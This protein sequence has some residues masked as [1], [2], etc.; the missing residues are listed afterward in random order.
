LNTEFAKHVD[1]NRLKDLT[2]SPDNLAV[3]VPL[4]ATWWASPAGAEAEKR[5]LAFMQN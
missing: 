5:W 4:S 3:Q 2:T 1:P